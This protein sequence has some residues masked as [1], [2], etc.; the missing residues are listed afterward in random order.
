[1]CFTQF[2]NNLEKCL[3][4]NVLGHRSVFDV[5][6]RITIVTFVRV[7]FDGTFLFRRNYLETCC[8]VIS[9]DRRSSSRPVAEMSRTDRRLTQLQE[10]SPTERRLVQ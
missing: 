6:C 1:M 2:R 3:K 5:I 10:H 7:T 8:A 9:W 4:I